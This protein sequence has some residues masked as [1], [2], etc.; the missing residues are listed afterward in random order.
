MKQKN[1]AVLVVI[2][3]AVLGLVAMGAFGV[4]MDQ[5]E[6]AQGAIAE[7]TVV[8]RA[9]QMFVA[10]LTATPPTA[11]SLPTNTG[12]PTRTATP[13]RSLTPTNTPLPSGTPT[14]RISP[15]PSLSPTPT[16]SPTPRP[17]RAP[18][19]APSSAISQCGVIDDPGTYRLANDLT[20]NGECIKI[21]SSYVVF[22]C[23]GRSIRGTN[24]TGYG[25]A[26]RKYGLLNSQ[27]PS[28]VEVRNC[29]VSNFLYGIFVEAGTKL[30]IHDNDSSNNFDD[31]DPGTRFGKFLGMTEGGGIRLNHTTDS[32]V[33]ANTTLNQAIGIDVRNSSGII[34][35]GNTSS[36]N[37]AWGINFMRTNNSEASANTTSDNVRK[38]TWGAGTVGFGC[39]AG[40]IVLQ[41][42]SNHNMVANNS[43]LGRNG[44]GVFIKAHAMPCGSHNTITGNTINSVLYNSVELSFCTGNK[45]NNNQMRDSLD[46]VWL[47]FANNTEIKGN[48]IANMRNHGVISLNS[49]GNTVSGNQI[50]NSNEA[51]YF[52]S[53][54]YDRKEFGF[55]PS[56]DYTSHDNCL[57]GNTLQNNTVAV[58]LR[59][60]THNQVTGNNYISNNRNILTQGRNNGNN[61]QGQFLF[62][63]GEGW[64]MVL[65]KR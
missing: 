36:N 13:L 63:F 34:V 7:R 28:Y 47:G 29:R 20:A 9:T 40:G 26:I 37:S 24:D 1:L 49:H 19:N 21:A 55:L 44:N 18:T 10:M 2:E 45:V 8:A 23:A 51:I 54:E 3:T 64:A 25:I 22:D 15:T 38:C 60:S 6:K 16:L 5:Y 30:V 17:T 31:V 59:D 48:V 27:T 4:L 52:Y 32:Q 42:G 41:D 43:V 62:P 56:G 33:L 35:R 65:P 11:T 53:E 57:C 12:T 58:H 61:L 50:I 39:D 46:G 14:P